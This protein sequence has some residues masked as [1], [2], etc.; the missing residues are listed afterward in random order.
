MAYFADRVKDTTTTTGTGNI[1]L[2]GTAPTGFQSFNAAF[3]TSIYF[4]YCIEGGSEWEV[5]LGHLSASTT[6]V[7]DV[8]YNSTNS[9]NAVNFS[10]GTKNVFCTIPARNI[11]EKKQ[12]IIKP[13]STSRSSTTTLA[14]DP[15]LTI[16]LL[17]AH[18]YSIEINVVATTA[19]TTPGIKFRHNVTQTPQQAISHTRYHSAAVSAPGTATVI[20]RINTGNPGETLI[21]TGGYYI[22]VKMTLWIL[23]HATLSSTFNFEWSQ[24]TSSGDITAVALGSSLSYIG[25]PN[26]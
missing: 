24:N 13:V 26:A 16:S 2:S 9:N 22:S 12:T 20:E 11:A 5:G 15:H 8:I 14:A 4:Y 19:T 10:S 23:S 25:T 17:P 1:T 7:R 21:C 18:S 6:L 3:G